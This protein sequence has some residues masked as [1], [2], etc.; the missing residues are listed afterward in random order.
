LVLILFQILVPINIV[1]AGATY[2]DYSGNKITPVFDQL[3]N[4]NWIPDGPPNTKHIYVFAAPWCPTSKELYKMSRDYNEKIQFRWIM[5]GSRDHESSFQNQVLSKSRDPHQLAE[6]FQKGKII[7]KTSIE[8]DIANQANMVGWENFKKTI[9]K[10][11]RKNLGFPTLVY[12]SGAEWEF[13]SVCPRDLSVLLERVK[14]RSL[15]KKDHKPLLST[16]TDSK[17]NVLQTKKGPN[18]PVSTADIYVFPDKRSLKIVTLAS[19]F[20]VDAEKTI[21]L[22]DNSKW[23]FIHLYDGYAGGFGGWAEKKDFK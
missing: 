12:S 9:N 18:F 14:E 5:V 22:G 21:Q 2:A 11:F 19:D 1:Y 20:A 7:G 15:E 3:D 6:L 23:I 13:L 4:L 10:E 16:I 17:I 8:S